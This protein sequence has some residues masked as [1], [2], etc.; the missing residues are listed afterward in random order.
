M[1]LWASRYEQMAKIGFNRV[2]CVCA[3]ANFRDHF[4]LRERAITEQHAHLSALG[5]LRKKTF[6]NPASLPRSPSTR[7]QTGGSNLEL[8]DVGRPTGMRA[9]GQCDVLAFTCLR[10]LPKPLTWP[11]PVFLWPWIRAFLSLGE[12]IVGQTPAAD[13]FDTFSE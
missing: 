8:D 7:M 5:V 13:E 12:F 10:C 9:V 2:S 11:C 6:T 1:R 4:P 3:F